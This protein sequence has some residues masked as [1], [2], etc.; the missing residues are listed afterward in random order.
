VF[1]YTRDDMRRIE[2]YIGNNP[3]KAGRPRQ[4][5]EFVQPYDGWLPGEGKRS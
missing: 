5:W 1:Q 2:R 4:S 3:V